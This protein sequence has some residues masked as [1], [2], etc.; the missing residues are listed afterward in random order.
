MTKYSRKRNTFTL[1]CFLQICMYQ[2]GCISERR[3]QL[4]KFASERG[5][6][7]TGGG[8]PQKRGGFQPRRK[9]WSLKYHWPLLSCFQCNITNFASTSEIRQNLFRHDFSQTK[10]LKQNKTSNSTTEA[11]KQPKNVSDLKTNQNL[12]QITSIFP[13]F[14]INFPVRHLEPLVEISVINKVSFTE[15]KGR[16]NDSKTHSLFLTSSDLL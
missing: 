8:F 16:I 11:A 12:H 3:G 2:F 7:Q 1:K 15:N 5:G 9:L 14:F 6:T 4:F 13:L 10:W